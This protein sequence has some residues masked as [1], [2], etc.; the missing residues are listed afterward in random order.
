VQASG[1][2]GLADLAQ[3]APLA[4]FEGSTCFPSLHCRRLDQIGRRRILGVPRVEYG[5]FVA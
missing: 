4:Q 2:S 5:A 3:S 1:G